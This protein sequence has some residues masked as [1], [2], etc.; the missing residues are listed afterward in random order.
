MLSLQKYTKIHEK[1]HTIRL[2][3]KQNICI[4]KVVHIKHVQV[5]FL[6]MNKRWRENHNTTFRYFLYRYYYRAGGKH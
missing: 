6:M 5:D 1:L 2:R 3:Q 4:I